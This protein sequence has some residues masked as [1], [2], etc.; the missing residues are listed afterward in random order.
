[1]KKDFGAHPLKIFISYIA[2]QKRLF[3][4]DMLCATAVS[5][6]D[7]VFPY[8]SRM[9]M[10]TLLPESKFRAFFIVMGL[11]FTAYVMKA[12]LYYLITVLGHR[13]GI[14]V[15]ADM[16]KDVFEHMQDLSCS[17]YD[18]NRTGVLMSHITSDLFDVT[19]LAHHGPENILIC[20]LTIVGALIVMFTLEWRLALV[21]TLVLPL[22]FAFTLAQRGGQAQDRGDILRH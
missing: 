2:G 22:C 1:M 9:S 20:S 14:L 6:I 17:Y 7:L 21:L 15:E 3:I 19:E 12:A 8:V 16:R 13:M 10:N 18:K 11:M 5:L 4:I